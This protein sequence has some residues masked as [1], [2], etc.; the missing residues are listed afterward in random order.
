MLADIIFSLDEFYANT[1]P[2]LISLYIRDSSAISLDDAKQI[3]QM[4]VKNANCEEVAQSNLQMILPSMTVQFK[5][6]C[7]KQT[8]YASPS[9][10]E[11]LYNSLFSSSYSSQW[12]I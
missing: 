12:G 5:Y 2:E 1:D 3:I 4:I 11:N 7:A 6:S 10:C 8:Y 9:Q